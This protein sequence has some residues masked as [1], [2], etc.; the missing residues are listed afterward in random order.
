MRGTG[1]PS[2]REP[3]RT[4]CSRRWP[5]P[6]R[7]TG[8]DPERRESRPL[9]THVTATDR[10]R[11]HAWGAWHTNLAVAT[12]ISGV[13]LVIETRIKSV[14]AKLRVSLAE[15][16]QYHL[17]L[18]GS[19]IAVGIAQEPD[20]RCSGHE[21]APETRHHAVGKRQP[22]GK[23]RRVFVTSVAVAIFQP[24]DSSGRRRGPGSR[25]SRRRKGGRL[26]PRQLPPG[27]LPRARTRPARS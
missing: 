13:D 10:D 14:H 6:G 2:H 27:S 23:H 18:V 3:G 15:T 26:R 9:E 11:R 25:S 12:A 21:H 20:V 24:P 22:V 19:A 7:G 5:R 17:P 4:G 8:T 1:F 16:G